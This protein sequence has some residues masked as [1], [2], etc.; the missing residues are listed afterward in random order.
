MFKTIGSIPKRIQ[1]MRTVREVFSPEKEEEKYVREEILTA[2]LTLESD[3]VNDIFNQMREIQDKKGSD[4]IKKLKDLFIG[5][6]KREKALHAKATGRE[7][8]RE[9]I[10][11]DQ[12]LALESDAM[13]DYLVRLPYEKFYKYFDK[14]QRL[15]QF[16]R[17]GYAQLEGDNIDAKRFDKKRKEVFSD[18]MKK[19]L[20]SLDDQQFGE[21]LVK[22][23]DLNLEVIRTANLK[24][25]QKT[26]LDELN[27]QYDAK[28]QMKV[29]RSSDVVS[30]TSSLSAGT[31]MPLVS[32][33][34]Q[35]ASLDSLSST[36]SHKATH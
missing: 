16:C 8:R 12:Y 29:G 13:K 24:R 25:I 27:R 21:F 23:K 28:H 7:Q 19:K 5:Q 33:S 30:E 32:S 20:I 11:G 3:E 18:E 14:L 31:P 1:L 10:N 2:L 6:V 9:M 22:I 35:R 4:R 36:A 26:T 15:N 17:L 34:S